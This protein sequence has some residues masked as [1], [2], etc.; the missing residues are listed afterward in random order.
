MAPL[1]GV[2]YYKPMIKGW[3]YLFIYFGLFV[4]L[5]F[6]VVVALVGVFCGGGNILRQGKCWTGQAEESLLQV[7]Q[8]TELKQNQGWKNYPN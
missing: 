6:V 1:A 7:S 5:F 3:L 2:L 8:L 4:C